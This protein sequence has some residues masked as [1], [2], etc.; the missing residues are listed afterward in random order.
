MI[1]VL[2]KKQMDP[3]LNQIAT[4]ASVLH[5]CAASI[6]TRLLAR[7]ETLIRLRAELAAL[8]SIIDIPPSEAAC[9]PPETAAMQAPTSLMGPTV[10]EPLVPKFPV[11]EPVVEPPTES[12]SPPHAIGKRPTAAPASKA[13]RSLLLTSL[14]IVCLI[15]TCLVITRFHITLRAARPKME[16]SATPVPAPHAGDDQS[17][18]ALALVRQWHMAGDDKS[19][20][21]RLGGV[22]E[23]PGGAPAWSAEMA[24]A[25]TYLVI[26][27]EVAGTPIYAFEANLKSRTVLPTPEA[28]QRLTSM[29]VRDTPAVL[30]NVPL[31]GRR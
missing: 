21:E 30:L 31:S 5:E 26:F 27:R 24:D 14:P 6:R 7:Q 10:A 25:D 29:R 23:H 11:V 19:L 22:V 2:E 28:A 4:G 17:A 8:R 1:A 13:R 16:A 12:G 20:L 3:T 9:A 18:E 15:G